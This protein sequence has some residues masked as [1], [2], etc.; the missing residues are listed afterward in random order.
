MLNSALSIFSDKC[1]R[2]K[3]FTCRE[4]H[5]S[6]KLIEFYRMTRNRF[7]HG[8]LENKFLC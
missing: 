5:K 8:K 4:M 7:M 2:Q 6:K 1:P 3:K